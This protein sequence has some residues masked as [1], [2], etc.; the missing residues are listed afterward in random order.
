MALEKESNIKIK[1]ANSQYKTIENQKQAED[2]LKEF[3]KIMT[4][5]QD[6][7][8][9]TKNYKQR[10]QMYNEKVK[11]EREEQKREEEKKLEKLGII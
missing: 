5:L 9:I 10:R 2:R 1:R 4:S 3:K 7:S 8:V 11:K 6:D